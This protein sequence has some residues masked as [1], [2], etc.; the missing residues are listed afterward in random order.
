MISASAPE[1]AT[2][3]SEMEAVPPQ[4]I[5]IH[6][7]GTED[8]NIQPYAT[9]DIEDEVE[10]LTT[11]GQMEP[12]VADALDVIDEQEELISPGKH[13]SLGALKPIFILFF[14][15]P[16]ETQYDPISDMYGLF[17]TIL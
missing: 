10:Y 7:P 2:T 1:I 12:D 14:F 11:V 9:E 3:A 8:D 16:E 4:S 6:D 17:L 15:R 13:L 5:K